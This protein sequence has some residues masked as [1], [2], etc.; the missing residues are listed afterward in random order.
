[1][2]EIN[3]ILY[4][5]GMFFCFIGFISSCASEKHDEKAGIPL[6]AF[7]MFAFGTMLYD[8]FTKR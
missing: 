7:L 5:S 8:E 2:K 1:M 6:T 3:I 4:L